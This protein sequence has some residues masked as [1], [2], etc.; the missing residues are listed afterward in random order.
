VA[1]GT[2]QSKLL[3]TITAF[4]SHQK[5]FADLVEVVKKLAM[6]VEALETKLGDI[7]PPDGR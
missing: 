2:S 4:A 3:E 7:P 1:T 5:Q 6:K